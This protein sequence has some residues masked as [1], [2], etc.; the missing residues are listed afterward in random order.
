MARRRRR[1]IRVVR[2]LEPKRFQVVD[3][4]APLADANGFLRA[5]EARGLSPT[6][7]RAYAFDLVILYR[8]LDDTKQDLRALTAAKMIDFIAAQRKVDAQ[9]N[10]INRRLSTIRLFYRFCTDQDLERGPGTV[11]P[12]PYYLGRGRDRYLGLYPIRRSNRLKLRVKTP[13]HLV[14]PA[15]CRRGS[16]LPQPSP[17]LSRSGPGA[18]APL[19]R[20]SLRR[21]GDRAKAASRDRVKT[22]PVVAAPETLTRR[23]TDC[24]LPGWPTS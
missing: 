3:G 15:D 17:T 13:R 5:L 19:L 18:A 9:P 23:R 8:W 16:T 1:S 4:D 20:P 7:L 6:T 24:A 14:E 12:A 11:P 21:L 10:S 2:G 22:G